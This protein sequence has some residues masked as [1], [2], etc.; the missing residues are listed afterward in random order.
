MRKSRLVSPSI[1]VIILSLLLPH[2]AVAAIK[3]GSSCKKPNATSTIKGTSVKC[4]KLGKKYVWREVQINKSDPTPVPSSSPQPKT[5]EILAP[6]SF[7]DLVE[8]SRGISKAAWNRATQIIEKNSP[9]QS[10]LE[11]LTGPNTEV[12]FDDYPKVLALVSQLF[13]D[14]EVPKNVLVIR[15]KYEDLGWAENKTREKLSAFDYASLDRNEGGRLVSSNCDSVQKTCVGSKQQ[16]V[17][18][19]GLALILQGIPKAEYL[20]DP[21]VREHLTSG[22]LEAHEYFHSL[23]RIP[24]LNKNREV[25]WPPAWFREGSATWVEHVIANTSNYQNYVKVQA[26]KRTDSCCQLTKKELE[27]FL[28]VMTKNSNSNEFDGWLNYALGS[29]FVEALV[30]LSG[31]DSII[32]MYEEMS[33]PAQFDMAFKRVYGI[34]WKEA[35]PI[36]ADAIYVNIQGP[37]S[38]LA[39]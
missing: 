39:K 18:S 25:P 29:Q 24:M 1:M 5:I 2:S 13:P 19:N 28:E 27:R 33:S 22:A 11:I 37:D 15:Y 7:N 38:T 34:E 21:K 20:N 36:L 26:I 9:R 32:A 4:M 16:T 6:T 14:R 8:R 3:I 10:S 23:Q 31:P 17:F 35:I 12:T 30:A